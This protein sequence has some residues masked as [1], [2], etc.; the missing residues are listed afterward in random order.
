MNHQRKR[1]KYR[2]IKF[3]SRSMHQFENRTKS[4]KFKINRHGSVF[5]PGHKILQKRFAEEVEGKS[6]QTRRGRRN[7][8]EL[9]IK[10]ARTKTSLDE[11]KSGQT[12]FDTKNSARSLERKTSSSRGREP[13]ERFKLK[14]RLWLRT[15]FQKDGKYSDRIKGQ[16]GYR[17]FV[18]AE[19]RN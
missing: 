15:F 8:V 11:I 12:M 13:L 18:T 9:N 10:L 3:S 19:K 5:T 4:A 14:R 6:P 1:R 2:K 7:V 17:Q 16:N